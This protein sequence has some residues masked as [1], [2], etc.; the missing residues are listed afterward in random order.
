M[1]LTSNWVY[2]VLLGLVLWCSKECVLVCPQVA[3]G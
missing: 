3:P 2:G 1:S